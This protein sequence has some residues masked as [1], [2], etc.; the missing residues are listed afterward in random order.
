MY[1]QVSTLLALFGD[2]HMADIAEPRSPHD[3]HL[4][5][6][7]VL[8]YIAANHAPDAPLDPANSSEFDE[9][10]LLAGLSSFDAVGSAIE[11]VSREARGYLLRHYGAQMQSE[12]FMTQLLSETPLPEM[13]AD[14]ARDRLA[15]RSSLTEEVIEEKAKA[16]RKWLKDVSDGRVELGIY[17]EPVRYHNHVSVA[18][19]GASSIDWSKY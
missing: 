9:P 4:V 1:C 5:T 8:A 15:N 16:A 2:E 17:T 19:G 3:A 18:Q 10:T 13:V 14:M 12:S 6:G 11:V 7:E